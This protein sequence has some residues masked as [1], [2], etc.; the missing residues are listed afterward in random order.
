[1]KM[2]AGW[3][4]KSLAGNDRGK[5]YVIKADDGAY[6]LLSGENGRVFRKNKK[7]VQVIKKTKEDVTSCRRENR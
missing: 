6:V 5:L 3:M 4:A 7:H 1:M 2:E